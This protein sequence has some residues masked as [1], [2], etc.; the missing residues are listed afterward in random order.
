[1]FENQT[2]IIKAALETCF[3]RVL[4]LFDGIN[5]AE[6]KNELLCFVGID[7]YKLLRTVSGGTGSAERIAE[8]KYLIKALGSK[9]M[10]A[11]E[12]CGIFDSGAMPALEGCGIKI[13]ELKRN[14]CAYSKE[15]GCYTVSA[16]L[17]VT[18]SEQTASLPE[19]IAFSIG[20]VVFGCMRSYGISRAVRVS[21]TPTVVDGIRTRTAGVR[22]IKI[23]VRGEISAAG[24]NNVCSALSAYL[25]GSAVNI[26][27]AGM[28]FTSMA[29]T[30]LDISGRAD[31]SS[32]LTVEFTGVNED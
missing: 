7:G 5:T 22:P 9:N 11:E 15:Q 12:L 30:G 3:D 31:G 17:T 16:E 1:M 6:H 14:S 29:M 28:G 10:S 8:V 24:A 2:S 25:G 18:E 27:V 13:R 19:S 4:D 21:E 23:T 20:N 26:S 32:D